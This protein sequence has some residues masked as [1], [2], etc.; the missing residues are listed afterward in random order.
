MTIWRI[1]DLRKVPPAAMWLGFGGLVPFLGL[2]LLSFGESMRD[3]A[4]TGLIGYGVVIL[5]FM[6]GCRWGFAAA[7][8][9][10]GA[11]PASLGLSVLPALYAWGAAQFADTQ[12]LSALAQT[13]AHWLLSGVTLALAAGV[14]LPILDRQGFQ[15]ATENS[16]EALASLTL[17]Y[18]LIPC[19]LKILAILITLTLPKKTFQS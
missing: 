13:L 2:G 4:V 15:S 10:E 12:A 17:L 5:S 18:A 1:G 3:V 6:G 11:S 8:L 16:A 14:V 7:G 19:G 9:G